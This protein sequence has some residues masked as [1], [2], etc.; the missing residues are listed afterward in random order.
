MNSNPT[1]RR[2]HKFVDLAVVVLAL[3]VASASAQMATQTYRL[4]VDGLACPFCAYGIEKQLS[5]IDGVETID[6][7]IGAGA[8]T[9]TATDGETLDE[10]TARR[11]VEAAGF[12][13]RDFERIQQAP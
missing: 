3:W 10:S 8:I 11:A 12:S 7:D 5:R 9:L 2:S 4:H 13:L 6:I 1:R